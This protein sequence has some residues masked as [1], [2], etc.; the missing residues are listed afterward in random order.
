M[1]RWRFYEVYG[2]W[3]WAAFLVASVVILVGAFIY[4]CGAGEGPTRQMA[5]TVRFVVEAQCS[6]LMPVRECLDQIEKNAAAVDQVL[7]GGR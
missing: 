3:L 5:R 1:T 4:G 2:H 7:D 6:D